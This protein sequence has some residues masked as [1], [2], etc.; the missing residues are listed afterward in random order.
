MPKPNPDTMWAIRTPSGHLVST[1]PTRREAL[2]HLCRYQSDDSKSIWRQLRR[3]GWSVVKV[4]VVPLDE[5]QA[6]Q[7]S[8]S[9]EACAWTPDTSYD[10]VWESECGVLYQFMADGPLENGFAFCHS[11]GRPLVVRLDDSPSP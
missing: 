8:P 2:R 1:F 4:A 10:G 3:E 5:W 11:C 6:M 9:A 7:D